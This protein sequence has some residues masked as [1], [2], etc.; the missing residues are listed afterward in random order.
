[1]A[2]SEVDIVNSALIK[3]GEA[4]LDSLNDTGKAARLA[5]QQYPLARRALL[6]GYRWN[7]AVERAVL[8]ADETPPA[9]GFSTRYRLPADYLHLIG[10]STG[11][12]DLRNYTSTTFVY[13]L[14]GQYVLTGGGSDDNGALNIFYTKDVENVALFDALFAEALA[15]WL[16][17]TDFA[18]A[19]S[20]AQSRIEQARRDFNDTIK[21]AR[22]M[23]A[24]E[25]SAEV[26]QASE[27][28]DSR[29]LR[30]SAGPRRGPVA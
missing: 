7:F 26:I 22:F 18:Y 13:K 12:E 4:T 3:I 6:R 5:R 29:H 20:A 28:V 15:M 25:S 9:F 2:G 21:R 30:A 10:I 17:F 14:E 19:L 23:S 1:M 8:A 24:I 11:D 27:W 16:A